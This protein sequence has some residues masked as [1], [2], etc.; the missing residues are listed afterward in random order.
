MINIDRRTVTLLALAAPFVSL[1]AAAQA[2]EHG[3]SNTSRDM[4]KVPWMGSEQIAML[5]YPGMTVMDLIGPHCMFGALMGV[6][7]D[8]VAKSLDPVTSDAGVTILPTATF[9]TCPTDLTVLFAPGGTDGTFTAAANP[10]TLAF[11]ADRGARAKYI[12]SVCSGSLILG[13]AGLLKGYKATSHW[14]CRDAL[15]GF[16]A[17]PT[18][19]RVVRDR[20]RITGAGV[21]AGLDFGLSMVAELRDQTYAECCQL[22]SEYDPAPPFNAGSMKTAPAEVKTA[23]IDLVSDF[24]KKAKAL[25]AAAKY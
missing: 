24:S 23:M 14:S 3:T 2:P 19:A 4:S 22:M 17:I 7:I 18:D 20:N 16:G 8:L 11:M 21:T 6:K 1:A 13:A 15:A 5:I 25:S 10:E 9:Q 12:T